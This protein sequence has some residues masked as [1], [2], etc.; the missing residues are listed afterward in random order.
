VLLVAGA[1]ANDTADKSA[2]YE[3]GIR[4]AFAR[5]PD[6]FIAAV[7]ER[8]SA[9]MCNVDGL[10]GCFARYRVEELVGYKGEEL[11]TPPQQFNLL[12]GA[13]LGAPRSSGDELALVVAIP[14]PS[15][16]DVYGA[17]FMAGT[18]SPED[19]TRFMQIVI[20]VLAGQPAA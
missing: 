8:T 16:K 5:S 2:F 19:R 10:D 20:D 7:V 3:R 12:C 1:S 14:I 6:H 15:T 17:A 13:D 4:G 9:P 18:F 11:P